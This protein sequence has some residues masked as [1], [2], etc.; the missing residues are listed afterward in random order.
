MFVA[1]AID[2]GQTPARDEADALTPDRVASMTRCGVGL[3]G[4]DQLLPHA[5]RIGATL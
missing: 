4:F 5:G 2:P 3:F 1:T